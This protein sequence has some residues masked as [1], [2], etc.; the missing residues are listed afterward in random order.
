MCGELIHHRA[1]SLKTGKKEGVRD[2]IRFECSP[3]LHVSKANSPCEMGIKR[4]GTQSAV[5]RSIRLETD[6]DQG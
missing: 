5:I 6:Y 1:F 3:R 4:V 2:W